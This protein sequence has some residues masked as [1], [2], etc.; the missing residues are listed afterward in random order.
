MSEVCSIEV[1]EQGCASLAGVL[2]FKSTPGLYKETERL[3]N[4]HAP[5]SLIDLS[6]VTAVDSTGLALL[7][8]WQATRQQASRSLQITNAPAS[9]MS[10]ARL[11]DAIEL[12]N[13]SGGASES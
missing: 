13:I 5:V 7:L 1:G 10:L 8:E 9:L 11:C 12:L 4:G 6:G 2:N 3:F